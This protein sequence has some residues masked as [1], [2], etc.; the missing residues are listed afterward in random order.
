MPKVIYIMGSGRS[1]STLLSQLLGQVPVC[2]A[3]GEIRS[4]WTRLLDDG[5]CGCGERFSACPFWSRVAERAFGGRQRERNYEYVRGQ[6]LRLDRIRR[7]PTLMKPTEPSDL[8]QLR[9]LLSRLYESVAAESDCRVIVDSSKTYGH[10]AI[11]QRIPGLDIKPVHLVRDPR[12]VAYSW[13]RKKTRSDQRGEQAYMR[14]YNP[15]RTTITRYLDVLA[16]VVP[17]SRPLRVRYEDL[18]A[19]PRR[20]LEAIL[21]SAGE[22]GY[23]S[24]DFLDEKSAHLK[25]VHSVAGNPGR[26]TTGRIE[27]SLD[28]TWRRSMKKSHRLAVSCLAAPLLVRYGYWRR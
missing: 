23:E 28:E 13:A 6:A 22:S 9:R 2:C 14:R 21:E 1:G 17:R 12:G 11:L 7:L 27:I 4:I 24:F 26:M 5:Y 3:V 15:L 16:D 10:L 25:P 20:T 19:S 8:A 18:I